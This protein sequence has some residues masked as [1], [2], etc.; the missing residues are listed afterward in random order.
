LPSLA[1]AFLAFD[2]ASPALIEVA[3]GCV[4]KLFRRESKRLR[5]FCEKLCAEDHD[6]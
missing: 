6:L 2:S 5:M 3:G 4:P 1:S